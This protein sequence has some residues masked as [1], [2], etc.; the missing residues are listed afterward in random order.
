[1]PGNRLVSV[2]LNC[3]VISRPTCA[4][5]Q[6]HFQRDGRFRSPHLW[7][8]VL[9]KAFEYLELVESQFGA[10]FGNDFRIGQGD[11]TSVDQLMAGD[12]G[13]GVG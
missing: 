2:I 4:V 11:Q 9:V 8:A 3:G 5:R 6:Q 13:T 7:F 12:L 10:I 1:M